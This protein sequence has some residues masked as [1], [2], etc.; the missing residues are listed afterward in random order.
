[1]KTGVLKCFANQMH[2][3]IFRNENGT[4]V[5]SGIPLKIEKSYR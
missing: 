5:Q 3:C 1:M 2:M 4:H